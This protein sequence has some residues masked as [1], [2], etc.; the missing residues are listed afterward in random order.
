ML[1]AA[2][3]QTRPRTTTLRG[4]VVLSFEGRAV[5]GRLVPAEEGVE[6][7][8]FP[9][10]ALPEPTLPKHVERIRDCVARH[11]EVVFKVQDTPPGLEVLGFAR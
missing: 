1:L 8:Y 2:A 7:R 3:I 6:S 9:V 5:D 10:D 11:T 4:E